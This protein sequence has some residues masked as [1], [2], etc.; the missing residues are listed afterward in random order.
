MVRKS[1]YVPTPRFGGRVRWPLPQTAFAIVAILSAPLAAQAQD[2]SGGK[3]QLFTAAQA[4]R[5]RAVYRTECAACHG[6]RLNDGVAPPLAGEAFVH[7]WGR[8]DRT[9]DDL[10]YITRTT[11]PRDGSSLAEEE[12]VE[13]LAFILQRNGYPA[14]ERPLSADGKALAS[15]RLEVE[16]EPGAEERRPAPEFIRGEGGIAP[17]STAVSQEE[18]VRAHQ[19]AAD[20]LYNTHDYTG[21]RYSDLAEIDRS[22]VDRLGAVCAYQVGE[23]TNFQ[24][25]PIIHRGVMYLTAVHATVAIDA[26]TCRPI[27]RHEW[28][29][30]DEEV[31]LN[32]RGV[33]IKDGRVVRATSDGY[34][35]ALDAEDGRFLWAR[36]VA[37]PSLGET[38]TMAPLIYDDLI[39]IGPAGSEN[40][41]SGWVGA[42]R[43]ESGE[44]VWRFKTV[45]G[46]SDDDDLAP[47]DDTWA[48]PENIPLGGGAVWTPFSLDVEKGELYVAVTNPAPDLPAHLRPGPNLY[49]NSL[50]ALDVR[51]GE[52]R[53]YRQLVP[54]DDHDWDLTQVSPLYEGRVNGETRPLVGTVGKDGVLRPLDRE[55]HEIVFET[56]VTTLENT[57]VPLTR[58]GVRVC[59]GI[60]GGVEWSGPAY[61]PGTHMLYTPAVDWCWT[62]MLADTVRFVPGELYLGGTV[63][64]SEDQQGWLTAVDASTGE[65]KW[66]YRSERP[67]VAAVTTTSGGLVF[68]GELTGDFI[69]LDAETGEVLYRFNT[70]GPIGGGVVTYQVDGKQFVATTSGRP[71][72]FWVDEHPGSATV[73]V[74]ALRD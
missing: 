12:Y 58:E 22:N 8:D 29:P 63:E 30:Q 69:A 31:W 18:L 16:A 1:R 67:M 39:I 15:I 5:G 73:F 2:V 50:V 48:N 3:P 45:P 36:Q 51:T 17:V 13:L 9:L 37:A 38:F 24:T 25:G 53:W 55:T 44:P 59:P 40:A 68:T 28:E 65:M 14:G 4:E 19:N 7:A 10:F 35:F 43:L 49:T 20:W 34:L 66:K 52:L 27:W 64:P 62:F 60:L 11:M 21:R 46:A 71:S 32:N 41:I 47:E 26:A 33:A 42:F 56:P 70:G 72:G 23:Q 57:E 6:A 74:F 61:H 54:N